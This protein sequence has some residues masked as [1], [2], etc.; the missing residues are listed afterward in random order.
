MGDLHAKLFD[1]AQN[2]GVRKNP[3]TVCLYPGYMVSKLTLK[4]RGADATTGA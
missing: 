4:S 1:T 2:L 3:D